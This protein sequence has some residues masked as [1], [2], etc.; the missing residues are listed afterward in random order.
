[1]NDASRYSSE[2]R[3]F[4]KLGL[5]GVAGSATGYSILSEEAAAQA[6]SAG[7]RRK[8]PNLRPVTLKMPTK[9]VIASVRGKTRVLAKSSA[10]ALA[11]SI[12]PMLG[13]ILTS[14]GIKLDPAQL[15]E[16]NRSFVERGVIK[17]PGRPGTAA[18]VSLLGNIEV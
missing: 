5:A 9:L 12:A 8:A 7:E 18:R 13:Q 11:N 15:Q 3:D 14:A 17:I 2:R 10:R 1:M 16:L 6:R 4:L